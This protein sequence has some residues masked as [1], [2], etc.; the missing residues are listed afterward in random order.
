MNAVA[1]FKEDYLLS[2]YRKSLLNARTLILALYP[3]LL[4]YKVVASDFSF[5]NEMVIPK[6]TS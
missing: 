2:A 4:L 6:F 1:D 5:Q 3:L